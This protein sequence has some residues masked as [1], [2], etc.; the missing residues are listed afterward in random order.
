MFIVNKQLNTKSVPSFA[1]TW[2]LISPFTAFMGSIVIKNLLSFLL[3]VNHVGIFSPTRSNSSSSP[4]W[5]VT[6]I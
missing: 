3:P 2:N 6:S 5:S 4:S 1:D